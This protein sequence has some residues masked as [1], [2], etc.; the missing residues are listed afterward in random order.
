MAKLARHSQA[1]VSDSDTIRTRAVWLYYAHGLTQRDIA[2]RLGISRSTV[3]RI[4]DDARRRAEVQIW[5]NPFP[6]DYADLAI[7]LENRFS[8]DEVV[9]AP[10]AYP[11]TPEQTA[12]NVGILLGQFMSEVITD[13]MVIGCGWGRTLSG[14]LETFRASHFAKVKVLSL[15]GSLVNARGVNP[16]DVSWHIANRLQAE[17]LLFP[18]PLIV[19]S[20]ETKKTLMEKCGL[21]RLVDLASSMN[22]AVISCG[23][24][25]MDGTSLTQDIV[26]A[27]DFN[28]LLGA[29]AIC[30][31]MCHFLD[32]DGSTVAH[33][34][35][36]RVM[37][38]SLDT[39][40]QADHIVL[41]SGGAQRA[42]AIRATIKRV[43]CN[44]LITDEAAAR[45]LLN[46]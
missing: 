16:V 13:G 5:L 35:H 31:T 11:M 15:L 38:I 45:A 12:K 22:I 10:S 37:S 29:G 3:I 39:V 4:L 46:N 23:E 41:A 18:A 24:I 32:K 1:F 36:D 8:L 40:A 26:S 33:P 14:S 34:I 44:T 2:E 21:D 25:G 9:I 30:D 27:D 28:T 7:R 19:D 17:C 42:Q 20:A 6:G 43:G